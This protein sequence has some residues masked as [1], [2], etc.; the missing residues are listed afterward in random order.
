MP[1]VAFLLAPRLH[2]LDL[3]GPA[4]VFSG[5]A[6]AG[7]HYT[8]R[9][10]A[11][12]PDVPTAQGLTIHAGTEWPRLTP[13]DLVIVPGWRARRL[14]G[15][16]GFGA[17]TLRRLR[18]HHEAGGT[19]ASVCAGADALGRA[20]LLDG[21]RCTTHHQ[22][23]DELAARHPRARVVRDV[24]Y[25]V[26]DG[27]ATSAGIASGIDLALHLL[28]TRHGP[29]LAA[30]VAR[31]MVGYA[32]RNGDEPQASAMLRHRSHLDDVVHRVQDLIDARFTERLP[33]AELAGSVG[34]G[35]RT[36]TRL[37]TAATGIT[38]LRYQ[39]ALRVERAEHLIGRGA[40]VESAAHVVGFA[41]ARML[42]RLRA[43]T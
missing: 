1:T 19:V 35:E 4:Q 18:E 27:V 29:A 43:R 28:A 30:R 38:P 25:V 34:C 7:H 37:F 42:R 39:Q 40:T 16:S 33:L 5:A 26:D 41:D 24:L 9:Y 13:E 6:D 20:G 32:R 12:R 17:A 31:A 14:V 3:A 23:Q 2:L 36:V 10:V 21:R 8:L 22:L 11:E 15:S